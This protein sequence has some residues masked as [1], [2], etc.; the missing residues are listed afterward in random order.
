MT[1]HLR[2]HHVVLRTQ[3]DESRYEFAAGLNAVIGSYG[4]GKSSLFELIKYGLGGTAE[5]MPLIRENLREIE[6]E[7]TLGATRRRF[8]RRVGRNR[9]DVLDP[10]DGT[11]L[12]EWP[13]KG[14]GKAGERLL[15][16][17]GVPPARLSRRSATGS[18]SEAL[19]FFDLYR[20]CYVPQND[21]DRSV[22]GHRDPFVNR[23]RRA[24]FEMAFG[25]TDD[26]LRELRVEAGELEQQRAAAIVEETTVRRFLVQTGAVPQEE[27]D[28]E[29]TRARAVL[30]AADTRLAEVRAAP[31]AG[32]QEVLRGRVRAL[33]HAASDADADAA[34]ASAA[35]ARDRAVLSQLALDQARSARAGVAASA[36]SGLEFTTC[37]RCLQ[38]LASRHVEE[39]HCLLC[40][41]PQPAPPRAA[42]D[43]G[44]RLREQ[45]EE[46]E[47]ILAEDV[48]RATAAVARLAMARTELD[49]AIS[50][51]E[52]VAERPS[53]PALDAAAEASA[54][55]ERARARLREIER[56]RDLWDGYRS[57]VERIAT[58]DVQTAENTVEQAKQA[59]QLES[60]RRRVDELSER[61]DEEM[62]EL[63]YAG[64]RRAEIDP[65]TYLPSVNDDSF[66]K[67]SVGGARKTLASVGYFIALLGYNLSSQE[68]ALPDLLL[69]DSPRKN[70][71]NTADD[72]AAGI[73][74]YYR[75]GLLAQA[76]PQAQIL[77]ADNGLPSL[78]PQTRRQINVI[79]LSYDRALLRDVEH[80]GEGA[81]ETV[82]RAAPEVDP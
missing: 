57:R 69:L 11:R 19:S 31:S 65:A 9:L 15:E 47:L 54:E 13:T 8:V 82:G 4:T 59:A 63:H 26:R 60:N 70:L 3:A 6:V 55:R 48:D 37:P 30:A 51:L 14:V 56:F 23:K 64:Y 20:Y 45:R 22:A 66:D 41:L 28:A 72:T 42:V 81:V 67:L 5:I 1:L 50:E 46:A 77:L 16:L 18:T 43:A 39:G 17:M 61:F 12:E 68:V 79:P 75:L 36:L 29:D 10:A 40:T 33:R 25:L 24:V 80:P 7:A 78:D 53:A 44:A 74:I 21:I 32:D 73:R 2:L 49:E 62:R 71:G 38:A 58:I 35:V 52:L 76:Y 34:A 27:L